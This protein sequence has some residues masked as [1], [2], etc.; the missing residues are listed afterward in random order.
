ME[1]IA[2][3][4]GDRGQA[5]HIH[6]RGRVGKILEEKGCGQLCPNLLRGQVMRTEM[7]HYS[8]TAVSLV[9]LT[10]A[11]LVEYWRENLVVIG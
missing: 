6:P 7:T 1:G 11:I 3:K 8:E 4:G 9:T 10:K 2:G 5:R